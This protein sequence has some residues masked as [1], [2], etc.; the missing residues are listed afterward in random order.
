MAVQAPRLTAEEFE[1]FAALP[2][3]A[4]R[5]LEYIGGE[6]IEVVSNQVSS[7]LVY[8]IGLFIGMYLMQHPHVEGFVT[9]SDGGYV[10]AGER[11][12]PDVAFV[13]KARQAAPSDRPYGLVPPDLAVEVLSPTNDPDA[14]MTKIGNYL[15]VGTVVWVVNPPKQTLHVFAPGQAVKPLGIDDTLNGGDVLPGFTLALKDLFAPAE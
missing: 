3:N 15:A 5:R 13:S 14:M 8:R 1:R 12:I 9:G 7:A 11:Y 6:V 4:D 10:I 2:A